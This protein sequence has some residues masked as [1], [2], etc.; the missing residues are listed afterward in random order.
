[1]TLTPP[2]YKALTV[3]QR[4]RSRAGDFATGSNKPPVFSVYEDGI[5]FE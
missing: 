3:L 2:G 5:L 4:G 1:M